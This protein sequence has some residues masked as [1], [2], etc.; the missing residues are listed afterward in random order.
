MPNEKLDVLTITPSAA[1]RCC[2]APL[3]PGSSSGAAREA[4]CPYGG[5]ANAP[6]M[7]RTRAVV[8]R[9]FRLVECG[10]TRLVEVVIVLI[11]EDCGG[12]RRR[13]RKP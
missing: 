10:V 7:S 6:R 1:V 5:S 9:V 4:L 2:A 8:A 11:A 12:G 13:L 3:G